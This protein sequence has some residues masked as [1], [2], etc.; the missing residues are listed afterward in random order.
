M[1]SMRKG[2]EFSWFR[3]WISERKPEMSDKMFYQYKCGYLYVHNHSQ[4]ANQ[5]QCQPTLFPLAS[6]TFA[7]TGNKLSLY[8]LPLPR[9]LEFKAA[10]MLS[11]NGKA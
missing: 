3:E 9:A 1:A 8:S 6:I 11:P 4:N 2:S 5:R 10:E 7:L